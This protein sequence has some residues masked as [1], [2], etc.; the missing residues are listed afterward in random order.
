METAGRAKL[1]AMNAPIAA[2]ATKSGSI[3]RKGI[4]GAEALGRLNSRE[5]FLR[6]AHCLPVD[7]P[8][9]WMMRQAGRALPEYRKLKEKYTFLQLAQTPEL[10]AEV[11]LQPIRRFGFDAAIIF[12]DILVIPEAMGVGYNFR[13]AGGVEMDFTIRSQEDVYKLSVDRVVDRLQ[14]VAEAL[15]LVKNELHGE[16][17]LLGFAGSPWTLANYMLDG[18]SAHDHKRALALFREDR[19][20]FEELC[21]KLTDAIISFLRMQ[22]RA[23]ADAVQLFDSLGGIIPGE[24]FRQASGVWLRE[25]VASLSGTVPIIVFSKGARE[26][27][28]LADTDADVIGVDYETTLTAARRGLGDNMALQGNLDPSCMAN[29]TPEQIAARVESLVGEMGDRDGYIFNLGHGLPPNARL[30]NIQAVLDTLRAK[31]RTAEGVVRKEETASVIANVASGGSTVQAGA[32]LEVNLDLVR[33]YNQPGPRYT[34]YPPATKFGLPFS[35]RELME[36]I[37]QNNRVATRDLSLYFHLPFCKS[38]CWYCGCNTIITTQQGQS[39]AY[40]DLIERELDLVRNRLNP[41][42]KV[43]QLHFGGGTPT[44][45]LPEE[46]WRLGEMIRDRFDIAADVEFG[47]EI[48]P[49]RLTKEHV[50]AL[51][52]IGCNRA[53]LGVQD[54]NPAVQAAVHRIQPK[55]MTAQAI[56]WLRELGVSMI[57]IDLIYGLPHQTPE[58]FAKTL[59]EVIEFQPDRLAV[60]SY[61]HVPW[62]KP[63]QKLLQTDALPGAETKLQLLKKTIEK[64][65]ADGQFVYIGMDH[66]ARPNDELT[67]AQKNKTLQRNFQGYSTR[68][69]ADIYSFGIS[70]ISQAE[71]A[72]W[73]NLKE[74]PLYKEALAQGEFP[75]ERGYFLTEEDKL[76]RTTIMRLM[77]DLGL[78]FAEMSKLLGVNFAEHFAS[79]ISSLS[80]LEADGLLE[81][82]ATGVSVT[83]TG[84]LFI[85]NIAMRFDAYLPEESERRFSRT[86]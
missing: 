1:T 17:A 42:R 60:F 48:D 81:R 41:K 70:S 49:R 36:R 62:I 38:L 52:A 32:K 7:R 3:L 58:S 2:A 55:E 53:S 67:L 77:C 54:H 83:E 82:S 23:G 75:I 27:S 56:T 65:T 40:L 6:A 10:A 22:I 20:L 35:T 61:A 80:D 76:R 66:F 39:S 12:S 34:S 69:N 33:K 24:E 71:G 5:R 73:Q 79:E 18:G 28:V 46:L 31:A 8:P 13:E 74:L 16:T 51:K 85:R 26:W 59:D 47:V 43:V 86:I 72:Y 63:S 57:N 21:G 15:R 45:L 78:N 30:E 50:K 64:L 14:Y 11:T 9:A 44:F 84:R 4:S 29:D 19:F 25:I 68:G 37:E